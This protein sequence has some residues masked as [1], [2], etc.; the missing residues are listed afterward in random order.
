MECKDFSR[1]TYY[2][3]DLWRSC[4]PYK[5]IIY[6]YL[7]NNLSIIISRLEPQKNDI[8]VLPHRRLH[9]LDYYETYQLSILWMGHC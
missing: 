1:H 7:P 4:L 6:K 9:E 2:D 5:Y 8:L 3:N